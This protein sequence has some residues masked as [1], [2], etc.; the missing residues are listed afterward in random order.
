MSIDTEVMKMV[1]KG[2]VDLAAWDMYRA[3]A[4]NNT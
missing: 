4:F 1:G 2:D 3:I